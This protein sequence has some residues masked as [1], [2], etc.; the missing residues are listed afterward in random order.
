V[1][2]HSKPLRHHIQ[3]Y[4]AI[5][6]IYLRM[7]KHDE[8]AKVHYVCPDAS[9]A[10]RLFRMFELIKPVPAA[11]EHVPITEKHRARFRVYT[12]DIRPNDYR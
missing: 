8:Y 9:F 3:R 10:L 6:T 11:G 12:L 7:M 5:F 2:L 1:E 4:E